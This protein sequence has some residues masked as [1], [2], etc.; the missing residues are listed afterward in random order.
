MYEQT[1]PAPGYV[2][3]ADAPYAEPCST[4]CA[5]EQQSIMSRAI[6]TKRQQNNHLAAM[7]DF[8]GQLLDRLR[9]PLPEK[10]EVSQGANPAGGKIRELDF[11]FQRT[12]KILEELD[13]RVHELN[14]I[15]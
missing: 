5:Q 13:R 2:R 15:A 4:D 11:E 1:K 10:A 9:G 7:S 14:N 12:E 8:L 6:S 3:G